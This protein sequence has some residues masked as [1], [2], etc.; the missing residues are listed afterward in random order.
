MGP[1]SNE[2]IFTRDRKGHTEK[3][4]RRECEDGGKD[5]SGASIN[6]SQGTLGFLPQNLQKNQP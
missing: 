5:W 4:R 3:H 2:S 1:K 6:T